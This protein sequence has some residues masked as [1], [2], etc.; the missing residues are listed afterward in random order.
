MLVMTWWIGP[1]AYGIFITAMSLTSFLASVARFGV[2]T[3]L[4][5]CESTPPDREYEVAFTIMALSS[6]AALLAGGLAVPLVGRWLS[7]EEFVA[8]YLVLLA[9]VP[10][11][12]L[13]GLPIAKLERE[14]NFRAVAG[15]ELA[16]QFSA[17]M[18]A[19]VLAL[20]GW[21]VWAPVF[22]MVA[23]QVVVLICASRLSGFR[24]RL[25]WDTDCARRMLVFG[26][27]FSLSVRAW[28][29]RSL[30]NP[31]VVGRLAGAEAV[32]F[33]AF[34]LRAA[35]GLG[36][37]R[38]AATRVS[39]AGLA[40]IQGQLP[41]FCATLEEGLRLQVLALGPLLCAFALAGPWLVPHFLGTRWTPALTVYP[42]VALGV[43]V[44]S[45]FNLQ[46]SALFVLERQ[47]PVVWAY[48]SHVV[49]LAASTFVFLP[50]LG[51]LGYGCAELAACA[52][53]AFIPL[54]LSQVA[55]IAYRKL[56]PW[57][58]AFSLPLILQ[59]LHRY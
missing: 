31:L 50:R 11:T 4:I 30:V 2:D 13:A 23:W 1:H 47:W 37:V 19:L 45:V 53:Y 22:G 32:A 12:A 29:L 33:V 48:C 54:A 21:G 27:G 38:T 40:K 35:E 9:T 59:V 34:A 8:P 46:A 20:A 26:F 18:L 17:F 25:A 39:I 42:F 14:L 41:R 10:V 57:L 56:L 3:Y 16:G 24:I 28:Q 51:I 55:A 43:L 36:F 44:N 52:A 5:R 7:Q 15:M 6:A 58:A 49:L